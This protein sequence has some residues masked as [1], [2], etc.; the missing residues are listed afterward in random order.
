MGRF[1]TVESARQRNLHACIRQCSFFSKSK[2]P[3]QKWLIA[4]YWWARE[5]SVT[6]MA[7]EN[8]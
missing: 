4:M 6:E 1:G 3:L 8:K 2:L 5:Y 7:E